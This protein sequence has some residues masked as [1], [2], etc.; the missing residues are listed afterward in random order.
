MNGNKGQPAIIFDIQ[1]FSLHDGPGIRTTVFLKGCPLSCAWCQNPESISRDPEMAFYKESCLG[2]FECKLVCPKNAI[3]DSEEK[4]VRHEVC[5]ACGKCAN[6]CVSRGLRRIGERWGRE[7][8]IQTLL[9]DEAFFE[10]SG[11]GI[12]FSG[13]EPMLQHHFLYDVL[14]YLKEKGLHINIETS[15]MFRW[16]RMER[17]LPF[18]DLIYFDLKH[19]DR[20]LHKTYTGVDNRLILENF[21]K[22]SR[23]FENLQARMPV[24]PGINDDVE[25][26]M[27]TAQY[28]IHAN[29]RTIH[30]LP[31]HPLGE[32]KLLR[33]HSSL[34]ALNINP[35]QPE[36][37]ERI[38]G[39]FK[40]EGIDVVIYQ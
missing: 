11:G 14:P 40:K 25:N 29:S 16:E 4:R 33:I 30:L 31:Y 17:M 20:S 35:H 18:F 2:C 5:D 3:M 15:G 39:L 23:S 7:K 36:D 37:L 13:G 27:K 26:I 9:K 38:E 19:M 28:L 22:L 10:E 1:R 24:I 8:L 21:L 6:V 34:R 12:T 32:S